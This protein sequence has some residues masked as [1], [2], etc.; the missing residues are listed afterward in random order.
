[1]IIDPDSRL[2]CATAHV[3]RIQAAITHG[4]LLAQPSQEPLETKS[5]STVGTASVTSLVSVPVVRRWI[6][7]FTLIR[8]HQLIVVV[9]AHTSTNNLS[10]AWH[11]TVDGFGNAWIFFVLLH[12][13][14]LD[15][16]GEMR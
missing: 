7:T 11:E 16:D 8:R 4:M 1:M 3:A 10:N 14:G 12:V 2:W 15:L 13:E 5:V 9:H 6:N